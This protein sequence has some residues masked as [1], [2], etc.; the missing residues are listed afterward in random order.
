[1]CEGA[2][3]LT[4]NRM[5]TLKKAMNPMKSNKNSNDATEIPH[6]VKKTKMECALEDFKL[7][8]TLGE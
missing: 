2:H 7:G 5:N 4:N 6:F 1:M 8:V 3:L